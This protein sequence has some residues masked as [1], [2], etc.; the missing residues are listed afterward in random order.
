ME[1]TLWLEEACPQGAVYYVFIDQSAMS[2]AQ[3]IE[4]RKQF[5]KSKAE[6][7]AAPPRTGWK[8]PWRTA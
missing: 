2:P 1:Y 5:H 6:G 4:W 8:K 7:T 3:W